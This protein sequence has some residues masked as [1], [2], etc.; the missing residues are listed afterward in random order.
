LEYE[1]KLQ[2]HPKKVII[3]DVNQGIPF[4]GYRIFYDHVLIRGKTLVRMRKKLKLRKLMIEKGDD[5][6]SI[7]A[8]LCSIREHLNR[9][10]AFGL[11][12][13]LFNVLNQKTKIKHTEQLRLFQ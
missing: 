4:V 8:C 5:D 10:D 11:Q 12:N 13:N 1:L 9:A 6:F 3:H 7:E 2:L